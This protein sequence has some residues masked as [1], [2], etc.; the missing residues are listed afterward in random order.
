M[1]L[2]RFAW[3]SSLEHLFKLHCVVDAGILDC[4]YVKVLSSKILQFLPLHFCH[5]DRAATEIQTIKKARRPSIDVR[6][7][8]FIGASRDVEV[9][10]FSF[11]VCW[12]ASRGVGCVESFARQ[13]EAKFLWC[14]GPVTGSFRFGYRCLVGIAP[15]CCY[16]V[17]L[18]KF[19]KIIPKPLRLTD[20]NKGVELTSPSFSRWKEFLSSGPSLWLWFLATHW[21]I[22]FSS[23][24]GAK[25]R[26][27]PCHFE[28]HSCLLTDE[29][30]WRL[31]GLILLVNSLTIYFFV[32]LLSVQIQRKLS[33]IPSPRGTDW[34]LRYILSS[35][36]TKI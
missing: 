22:V 35:N 8:A 23:R 31:G 28:G 34:G 9:L 30:L 16:L 10:F 7:F 14:L 24:S 13:I 29:R 26:L 32:C 25:L 4:R 33:G 19:P 3:H 18:E 2:M 11:K 27:I 5:L 36:K 15:D 21:K 1:E 20:K 17:A 6:S 12:C